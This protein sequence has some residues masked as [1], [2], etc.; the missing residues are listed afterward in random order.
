[1]N[2]RSRRS[3]R[4]SAFA[5]VLTLVVLGVVLA[6][7]GIAAM[8]YQRHARAIERSLD[9][10][11][12]GAAAQSCERILLPMAEAIISTHETRER[13]GVSFVLLKGVLGNCQMTVAVADEQAKLNLNAVFIDRGEQYCATTV[14][15]MLDQNAIA[16]CKVTLRAL[17]ID[18]SV[19]GE[20]PFSGFGQVFSPNL[21]PMREQIGLDHPFDV[22]TLWGDGA[23]NVRRATSTVLRARLAGH[24]SKLQID[25]LLD[26]RSRNPLL[27]VKDAMSALKVADHNSPRR[28]GLLTD[29]SDCHSIHIMSRGTKRCAHRLVV[30]ESQMRDANRSTSPSA[31]VQSIV[32]FEW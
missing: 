1:M 24:Y 5:L 25:R 2:T 14:A 23:V 26:E 9:E 22:L 27:S 12:Q 8:R 20:R 17:P 6:A 29:T 32:V 15:E 13:R 3:P 28:S 19:K 11:Q 10:L 4:A 18:S 31:R 21:P 16:S 30:S 7:L